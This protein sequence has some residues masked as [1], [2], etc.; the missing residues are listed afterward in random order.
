[1]SLA[2]SVF[3]ILCGTNSG[4]ETEILLKWKETLGARGGIYGCVVSDAKYLTVKSQA[5]ELS[6]IDSF[7][8]N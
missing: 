7:S 5:E 2:A 4:N 1:M 3:P 6:V 8:Y